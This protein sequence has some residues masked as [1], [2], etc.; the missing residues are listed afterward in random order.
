MTNMKT[1]PPHYVVDKIHIPAHKVHIHV[2]KYKV[3]AHEETL[4]NGKKKRIPAHWN[5]HHIKMY[6]EEGH[7]IERRELRFGGHS[8]ELYEH[9]YK[10]YYRKFREKGDSEALAKK[11]A[12]SYAGGTI[13]KIYR[14]KE[15]AVG[16]R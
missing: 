6:N 15:R 3:K 1:A 2:Y 4:R 16:M 10:S 12:K 13:G 14:S 11:K 9:I 5:I 8:K 7:E